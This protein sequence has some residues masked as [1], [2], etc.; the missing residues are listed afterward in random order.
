MDDSIRTCSKC[1]KAKP[2]SEYHRDKRSADGYRRQC[3]SCRCAQTMEWWY[4]NQERQLA[5]HREYVDENRERVREIDRDRYERDRDARIDLIMGVTHARRARAVGADYDFKVTRSAL[6]ERDGNRCH[7]CGIVMDFTRPDRKIR[8]DKA[9]IDHVLAISAG[10][11]HTFENTVLACWGCNSEKRN[12]DA[13]TFRER[14]QR[15]S[16]PD[17]S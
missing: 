1:A 3:K 16:T 2:L 12:E 11:G 17:A 14:V 13:E 7:Y 5:R 10:G 4:A 6:R 9:T 8:K 15:R